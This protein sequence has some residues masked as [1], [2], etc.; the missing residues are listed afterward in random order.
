MTEGNFVIQL[1]TLSTRLVALYLETVLFQDITPHTSDREPDKMTLDTN[2]H[3][4]RILLTGAT[5]F[6]GGTI[7]DT[8]LKSDSN[9]PKKEPITLLLR[10]ASRTAILSKTFQTRINPIIYQGL[11]DLAATT[12]VASQHDLVINATLGFHD[13]SAKA[14]LQ[15][16]AQRKAQT[17]RDVYMI[18]LSGASNLADQPITGT[19]LEERE[20]DDLADDIY[21]YECMRQTLRPYEQRSTELGVIDKGLELGVKT[22]VMM[23][24]L[25]FGQGTGLFNRISVQIPVYIEAALQQGRG[26]VVGE[27][28][29]ELDHVHVLDLAS[30]YE[31]VVLEILE[32]GGERLPQGK[33]GIVFAGNGRHTW[34]EVAGRVAEACVVEGAIDDAEVQSLTLEEAVEPFKT[35]V[36]LV[37]GDLTELEVGLCCNSRTVASVARNLGWKPT[38]GYDEWIGGFRDDVKAV[39]QKKG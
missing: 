6:I 3:S 22:L 16:L 13:A 1:R 15:G 12:A 36:D 37:G 33:K 25:I 10:D 38:R 18:Q 17:G 4:P 20:F 29:G 9:F 8:L 21:E 14:L 2:T 34:G 11:D 31:M 7:L 32:N 27:G 23:P 35:Y 26:V 24:P 39:L 5:G 28:K 30:L 19:Y